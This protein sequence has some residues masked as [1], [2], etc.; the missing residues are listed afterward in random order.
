MRKIL[1][2]IYFCV[3]CVT[4][5][6]FGDLCV[7]SKHEILG[8]T[9]TVK[10]LNLQT[11]QPRNA[12][13]FRS[14][15]LDE[16][17]NRLIVGARDNVF[18][19]NDTTLDE[20]NVYEWASSQDDLSTC[21]K[22]K[23]EQRLCR[24]YVQFLAIHKNK[25]V[26]CGTNSLSPRHQILTL[27]NLTVK[28]D[29]EEKDIC[30]APCPDN[31]VVGTVTKSGELI[32]ATFADKTNRYPEIVS[33]FT[34]EKA[35]V[36]RADLTTSTSKNR[37]ILDEPQFL[38]S[39]HAND[40]IYMFFMENAAENDNLRTATVARVCD[41]DNGGNEFFVKHMWTTL[42]KLRLVCSIKVNSREAY[43]YKNMVDVTYDGTKDVFYGAFTMYSNKKLSS[44]ICTFSRKD[45]VNA[46]NGRFLRK[47]GSVWQ[48]V[49]N[50]D[51]LDGCTI[52]P[53]KLEPN[54][55]KTSPGKEPTNSLDI[56]SINVA[57]LYNLMETK[58][59]S[60]PNGVSFMYPATSFSKFA[61]DIIKT[62]DSSHNTTI[63]YIATD[64]GSV[65]VT[66]E[67]TMLSTTCV[68]EELR[69]D[70]TNVQKMLF[71]KKQRILYLSS[72]EKLISLDFKSCG[73]YK[74]KISCVEAH[75]PLCGWD[76]EKQM[77]LST[78]LSSNLTQDLSAC[79][80]RTE[81]WGGW[82]N[83]E[84][85]EQT[86]TNKY[87]LCRKRNCLSCDRSL[88]K[89]EDLMQ[90][91]N[92]TA[93]PVTNVQAWLKTGAVD[94]HW[95]TWES[96]LPC[97]TGLCGKDTTTRK[98]SC[99]SPSPTNGGKEC[100]GASFECKS[101]AKKPEPCFLTLSTWSKWGACAKI[102]EEKYF[103][104][105]TRSCSRL[106]GCNGVLSERRHCAP[107]GIIW[108]DWSKCSCFYKVQHRLPLFIAGCVDCPQ[109]QEAQ[110]QR[111]TPQNC[112]VPTTK[113][114]RR[115]STGNNVENITTTT[116]P[117]PTPETNERFQCNP[118]GIVIKLHSLL[119]GIIVPCVLIIII[120]IVVVI[121]VRRKQGQFKVKED[122][123]ELALEYELGGPDLIRN[124]GVPQSP[125]DKKMFDE[126]GMS[127]RPNGKLSNKEIDEP[128]L[129]STSS[130]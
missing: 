59:Y 74:N 72:D 6:V 66:Y 123:Q 112:V 32:T 67:N 128:L 87:C 80:R 126:D 61:F 15:I 58:V 34:V 47:S 56:P 96:W 121:L 31:T 91:A 50:G 46:F 11:F 9:E 14:F 97:H 68:I 35:S 124:Q 22:E 45:L 111:C 125:N 99:T 101:C 48:P 30:A 62:N 44:A 51:F 86:N 4:H 93:T 42:R 38:S 108:G 52:K 49:S 73:R 77:C 39:I 114:S 53:D 64:D 110:Y 33:S 19:L 27:N 65:F 98:R 83:W 106:S 26:M 10:S 100:S 71:N 70:L 104:T 103:Q 89:G 12:T 8:K 57:I 81:Y 29:Q 122:K 43:E 120:G 2:S 69:T 109:L 117:L 127:F 129:Q 130:V 16:K 18:F 84:A 105:R 115:N 107:Q 119:I 41:T 5:I 60:I 78:S 63:F 17:H 116:I 7:P 102:N 54:V 88:C 1:V 28:V 40:S 25:L 76:E 36:K 23:N 24:N 3:L 79:P 75:N 82:S 113:P 13:Y 21:L 92:C 95:S 37:N 94:G 118:D 90:V 85:C 55:L 20:L